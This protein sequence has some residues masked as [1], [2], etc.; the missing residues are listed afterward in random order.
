MA[1]R[2]MTAAGTSN[3]NSKQVLTL[4]YYFY[5][6]GALSTLFLTVRLSFGRLGR[7]DVKTN[8]LP[9]PWSMPYSL[10]TRDESVIY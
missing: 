3:I 2:R 8:L 9:T 10:S 6:F 5:F 7:K 1:D 4:N